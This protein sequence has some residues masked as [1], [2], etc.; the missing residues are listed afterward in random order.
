MVSAFYLKLTCQFSSLSENE[1]DKV[2]SEA[3]I[4]SHVLRMGHLSFYEFSAQAA[5]GSRIYFHLG[6]EIEMKE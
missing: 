3:I 1:E 4:G 2:A 5:K 6:V